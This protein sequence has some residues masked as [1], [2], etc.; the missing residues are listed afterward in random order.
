MTQGLLW[1]LGVRTKQ[2]TIEISP[3]LM[4][5]GVLLVPNPSL[6]ITAAVIC[7]VWPCFESDKVQLL[8]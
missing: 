4:A 3:L 1:Q 7:Q 5:S 6:H 2:Q 8:W